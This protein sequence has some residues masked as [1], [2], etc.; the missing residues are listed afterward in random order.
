MS[1]EQPPQP[2]Q[3]LSAALIGFPPFHF[4]DF[5]NG[6]V[7]CLDDME[8]VQDQGGLGTPFLDGA[9]KSFTHVATGG[10]N[11]FSLETAKVRPPDLKRF[12]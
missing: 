8:A 1:V 12:C 5:V 2:L 7:K 9:D 4:P 11:P 3:C 6:L 10:N